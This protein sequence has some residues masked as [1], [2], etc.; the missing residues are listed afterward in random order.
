MKSSSQ[1]VS[2]VPIKVIQPLKVVK[3]RSPSVNSN[4]CKYNLSLFNFVNNNEITMLYINHVN[5]L[6]TLL[7]CNKSI[8]EN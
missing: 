5:V 3:K 4:V 2:S 1:D 8:N 6:K 7:Y